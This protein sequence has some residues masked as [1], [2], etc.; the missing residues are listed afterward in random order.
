MKTILG[1]FPLQ[2]KTWAEAQSMPECQWLNK[3]V[4]VSGVAPFVGDDILHQLVE[5]HVRYQIFKG[6]SRIDREMPEDAVRL[7]DESGRA[8]RFSD[9]TGEPINPDISDAGYAVVNPDWLEAPIHGM[10]FWRKEEGKIPDLWIAKHEDKIACYFN[11]NGA[12]FW[13]IFVLRQPQPSM[14]TLA[15]V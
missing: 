4:I 13:V 5:A 8:L 15:G 6:A 1:H 9:A 3:G 11:P 2:E 12:L 14:P 7:S 10:L